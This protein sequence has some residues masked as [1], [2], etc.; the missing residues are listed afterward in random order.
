[1]TAHDELLALGW[2]LMPTEHDD[3]KVYNRFEKIEETNDVIAYNIIFN[4]EIIE[5]GMEAFESEGDGDTI[6]INRYIMPFGLELGEIILKYLN[7][8]KAKTYA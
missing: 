8:L 4:L 6:T 3:L 7:E 1:M 5:V 2:T